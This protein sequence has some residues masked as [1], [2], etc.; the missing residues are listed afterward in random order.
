MV[1]VRSQVMPVYRLE[2]RRGECDFVR[3]STMAKTPRRPVCRR[4]GSSG[5]RACSRGSAVLLRLRPPQHHLRHRA[6]PPTH[7]VDAHLCRR[8][9]RARDD[10]FHPS[11][12]LPRVERPDLDRPRESDRHGAERVPCDRRRGGRDVSLD[13]HRPHLLD[14][15]VPAMGSGQSSA[16]VGGDGRPLSAAPGAHERRRAHLGGGCDLPRRHGGHERLRR[17]SVCGVRPLGPAPRAHAL[18]A[19]SPLAELFRLGAGRDRHPPPR[20]TISRAE[21]RARPRPRVLPGGVAAAKLVR[22][23]DRRGPTGRGRARSERACGLERYAP[24]RGAIRPPRRRDHRRQGGHAGPAG[25]GRHDRPS[26][27]PVAG[28][29]RAETRRRRARASSS[30]PSSK[31]DGRPRRRVARRTSSSRRSRTSSERRSRRSSRGPSCSGAGPRPR[32]TPS[33]ASPPSRATPPT[34]HA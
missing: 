20:R 32:R 12:P 13:A 33:A 19:R 8:V 15:R 2:R 30:P 7:P 6:L 3:V 4:D 18:R 10:L 28:R 23:A 11:S 1:A 9:P 26:D 21:R 29:H 22:A 5:R 34:W 14:R 31:H 16:R 24:A 25:T 17:R 27:D